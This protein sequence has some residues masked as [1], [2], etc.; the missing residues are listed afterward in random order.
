MKLVGF[1]KELEITPPSF[2]ESWRFSSFE[3]YLPDTLTPA[4]GPSGESADIIVSGR[5]IF[6]KDTIQSKGIETSES[7]NFWKTLGDSGARREISITQDTQISIEINRT[8]ATDQEATLGELVIN[9]AKGV[10][11]EIWQSFT[12]S[13]LGM[14]YFRTLINL[15]DE[16]EVDHAIDLKEGE[17]SF[18]VTHFDSTLLKSSKLY[19]TYLMTGSQMSRVEINCE[20]NGELAHADIMSL[21][22]LKGRSQVDLNSTIKHNAPESTTN[23]LAKNLLDDTSKGIFTGKVFIA[24]NAQRVFAGQLNRNLLLSKKAH[25]IG[26]PQLEI[27]ADDVKCSHGSTT[28]RIGDQEKF[29]LLSRGINAERAN[30]LLKKAFVEEVFQNSKAFAH[31]L[32]ESFKGHA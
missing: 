30:Q 12:G 24:K 8:S 16:A 14:T 6:I 21:A 28:G 4:K 11:A 13:E 20:L 27:F 32:S 19:Q 18:L 9:V 5:E 1:H 15:Q 23:Q 17:S 10:K 22:S 25:A 29:Y 2:T 31:K 3:K 26:Q 7:Q